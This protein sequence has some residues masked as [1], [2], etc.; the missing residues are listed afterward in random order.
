MGLI[1]SITANI[2]FAYGPTSIA[3]SDRSLWPEKISDAESFDRASLAEIL[4]FTSVFNE[5]EIMGQDYLG[6]WLNINS[7]SMDSVKKWREKTAA[8]L[9]QNYKIAAA[10]CPKDDFMCSKS[11][12]SF[13]D[14]S[15]VAK[16]IGSKI[17]ASYKSWYENSRAFHE[18]YI[19]EQYRL[20]A[21]FPETTSEIGKL[22]EDE[23]NGF[24]MKDKNFILTFDDGPSELPGTTDKLI[25]MLNKEKKTAIFFMLG[26][27]LKQ[28]L[29]TKPKT[30]LSAI[31][32]GMTVASH[33]MEH[34]SHST[35]PNWKNSLD[36]TALLLQNT[37]GESYSPLFRPPY[38]K[39]SQELLA[40]A[41]SKGIRTM[42]WN[43][44][45]QDWNNK[46]SAAQVSDRVLTLMLLWRHGIILFHDI[47]D[48]AVKALP[49]M[50][51]KIKDSEINWI[52]YSTRH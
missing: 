37:F 28:R 10:S 4:V 20:A 21:L 25:E 27:N 24:E 51:D 49:V 41:K 36:D 5:K 13:K 46:I 7:V 9:F 50:F 35:W 40:Y 34:K 44:D 18:A 26:T 15:E 31:Y 33:G 22:S 29:K 17:P 23:I 8:I 11:V 14:L 38:G 30:E 2:A 47:H 6:K 39:R 19:H 32:K 42:L 52:D 3:L 45:S 48:K 16:G 43:I 12:K 1:L